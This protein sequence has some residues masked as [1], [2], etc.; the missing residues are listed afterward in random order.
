MDDKTIE[1]LYCQIK[2]EETPD[3]WDRIEKA[4]PEQEK[5]PE[6]FDIYKQVST[7]KKRKRK[8]I[9]IA[10]AAAC[11]LIIAVPVATLLSW[12]SGDSARSTAAA[13]ASYDMA[14]GAVEEYDMPA[15]AADEYKMA[16]MASEEAYDGGEYGENDINFTG[17]AMEET[18]ASDGSETSAGETTAG[19]TTGRKLI[20]TVSMDMETLE[21][22]KT[23]GELKKAVENNGGYFEYSDISGSSTFRDSLKYGSFTIRI[24]QNR[25]YSFVENTGNLGNVLYTSENTEDITLKYIDTQSHIEALN[26][27]QEKLMELMDKA[28][29]ME[30]VLKIEEALSD[31]RYQLEYYESTKKQYDNQVNYSTVTL[32]IREVREETPSEDI[33]IGR[34]IQD[35]FKET[36]M[37]L[38]EDGQDLLVW[39]ISSIPY[40]IIIA[41]VGAVVILIIRK[42]WRRHKKKIH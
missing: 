33:G 16:D 12:R 42:L 21:F 26:A 8:Y 22:D 32:S 23:I 31:V 40:F 29:S 10:A 2:T 18:G 30:D 4:L 14:A 36:L 27:Q 15:E 37:D 35:A 20:K 41:A 11:L 13:G 19:E 24:P 38:S 1:A 9:G 5:Q 25:L 6:Q 7:K 3:V 34:R 28:D 39:F 17:T